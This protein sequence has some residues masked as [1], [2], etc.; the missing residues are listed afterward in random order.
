MAGHSEKIQMNKG[1]KLQMKIWWAHALGSFLALVI[2]IWCGI[3]ASIILTKL[4]F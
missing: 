1:E 3:L 2:A 4:G